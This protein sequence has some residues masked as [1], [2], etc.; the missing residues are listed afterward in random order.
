MKRIWIRRGIAAVG[1]GLLFIG[2]AG[3][4]VMTLW[5]SLLPAIVGVTTITWPQALGLLVLSRL[6]FGGLRLGGRRHWGGPPWQGGHRQAY[7]KQKMAE[8]FEQMS[9]EQREKMR[10]KWES[11]CGGKGWGGPPWQEQPAQPASES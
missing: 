3:F 10:Q 7:W 8:R 5:N 6:L 2:L 11:R 1:F 4:L 9:P